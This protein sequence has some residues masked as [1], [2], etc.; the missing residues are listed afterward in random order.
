M[1]I[2]FK[3]IARKDF[4]MSYP[5][6]YSLKT[7]NTLSTKGSITFQK[8]S[9]QTNNPFTSF[10]KKTLFGK[11]ANLESWQF[12]D[13]RQIDDVVHDIPHSTSKDNEEGT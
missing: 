2:N 1:K 8:L 9:M 7:I 4:N 13:C 3:A 11:H 10:N 12:W 5:T 6:I